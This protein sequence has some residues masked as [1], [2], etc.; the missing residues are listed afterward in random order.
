MTEQFVLQVGKRGGIMAD[1]NKR[2]AGKTIQEK[3]NVLWDVANSLAG[4]YKPHEY[5]LVILPMAV[6]KRFHDCLLP[7]YAKVQK[8]FQAKKHLQVREAFLRKA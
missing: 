3:A 4:L 6:V 8:E 2:D 7:T 5:G 1:K